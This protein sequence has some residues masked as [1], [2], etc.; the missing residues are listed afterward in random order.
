MYIKNL[1]EKIRFARNIFFAFAILQAADYCSRQVDPIEA[2]GGQRPPRPGWGPQ[3]LPPGQ[4]EKMKEIAQVMEAHEAQ[5]KEKLEKSQS[6]E[7]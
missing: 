4:S 3:P 7:S 5:E 6:K 1:F 2:R